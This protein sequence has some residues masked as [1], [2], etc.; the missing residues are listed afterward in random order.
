[1]HP[2][3]HNQSGLRK[4]QQYLFFSLSVSALETFF[5]AE[6][7]HLPRAVLVCVVT[8]TGRSALDGLKLI[9]IKTR[10]EGGNKEVFVIY[11]ETKRGGKKRGQGER[12]AWACFAC[13]GASVGEGVDRAP[14][15]CLQLSDNSCS[16][17]RDVLRVRR[18]V[19]LF[20]HLS[21]FHLSASSFHR[22]DTR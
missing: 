3:V 1:M 21:L 10:S 4:N 19:S 16:E 14:Q 15:C 20:P 13:T 9:W 2:V 5:P 12:A 7:S 6:L 11:G 8:I 22:T 18:H 17:R